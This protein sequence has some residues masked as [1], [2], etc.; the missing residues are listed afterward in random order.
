MA[1]LK[2]NKSVVNEMRTRAICIHNELVYL[3]QNSAVEKA[4]GRE[5]TT[6]AS[7]L[8]EQLEMMNSAKLDSVIE[9]LAGSVTFGLNK[10]KN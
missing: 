7:R 8:M 10:F 3:S 1:T 2:I 6:K 9:M 4:Q 5:Y